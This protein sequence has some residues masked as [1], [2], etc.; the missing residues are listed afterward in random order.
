VTDQDDPFSAWRDDPAFQRAWTKMVS[1]L[2]D[3]KR[4][5]KFGRSKIVAAHAEME[6][7][8]RRLDGFSEE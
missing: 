6:N 2:S 8:I 1:A 5:T 7:V 4:E 3:P